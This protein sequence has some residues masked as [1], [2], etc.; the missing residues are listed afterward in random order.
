MRLSRSIRILATLGPASDTPAMIRALYEAGADA[1]RLNMSHG[2]HDQ[3]A[4]LYRAV[5]GVEDTAG[6][7][8]GILADLQ[9]PKFR[10]GAFAEGRVM[11]REGDLFRLDLD[12]APGSQR[13]ACLPHP[14]ILAALTPGQRLLLVSAPRE[15]QHPRH[16]PTSA[17]SERR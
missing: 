3:I 6:R 11:L 2:D 9:G 8:I 10:V 13:R 16:H 4:A 14:E 17:A 1:F 12:A 5:R 7:P 15:D